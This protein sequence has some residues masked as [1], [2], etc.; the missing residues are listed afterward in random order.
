MGWGQIVAGKLY[1]ANID[2]AHL[3]MFQ[4][5][6]AA[7]HRVVPG[8]AADRDR[9]PTQRMTAL[10]CRWCWPG[11]LVLGCL[12]RAGAGVRATPAR[13]DGTAGRRQHGSRA[14]RP[15]RTIRCRL[16]VW[17]P[18]GVRERRRRSS[19]ILRAGADAHTK[20]ASRSRTWRATVS[21]SSAAT[22]S[23]ATPPSIPIAAVSIDLG[24][25][26]ALKAT[27]ERGRPARRHAGQ[28]ID[29]RPARPRKR[30][31]CQPRRPSRPRAHRSHGLS[32]S[33]A[34]RRSR[35]A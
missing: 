20:A 10:R 23:R 4:E 8:P 1:Q 26:A 25:D 13:A 21:W 14:A 12:G 22:T 27:I 9:R 15:R 5:K 24:S 18:A 2:S 32:R 31:G 33:A 17:Y 16:T 30:S 7:G 6:P 11:L 3:D 29:R 19:C 28:S 35:R 34:R